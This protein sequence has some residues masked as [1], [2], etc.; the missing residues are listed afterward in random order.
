MRMLNN[1]N[2]VVIGKF[3]L[4]MTWA[5][6]NNIHKYIRRVVQS[7]PNLSFSQ[8]LRSCLILE[9]VNRESVETG[10]KV[11]EDSEI[12]NDEEID[13]ENKYG[14]STQHTS[15]SKED[16]RL[17]GNIIE[18]EVVDNHY[19]QRVVTSRSLNA[20][21]GES[22]SVNDHSYSLINPST[23]KP[24]IPCENGEPAKNN[25]VWK[26]R[27]SLSVDVDS[28]KGNHH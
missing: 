4:F 25:E 28:E 23:P 7:F 3:K 18:G 1:H 21:G 8:E 10:D 14:R 12:L 19:A 5:R 2:G 20:K 27:D 9:I 6:K 22:E 26:V 17:Y 15:N 11:E 16:A 24:V 13:R